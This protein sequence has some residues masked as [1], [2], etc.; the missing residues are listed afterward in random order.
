MG[1]LGRSLFVL[2]LPIT[3]AL[4]AWAWLGRVV[5][6]AGGWFL[7]ILPIF[8]GPWLVLALVLT[9]VLAWT[10]PQRPRVL[11]RRECW[12]LAGLWVGL[13][14]VGLFIVDVGDAPGSEMSIL[15]AIVGDSPTALDVSWWLATASGLLAAAA[16]LTLIVQLILDRAGNRQPTGQP[17]TGPSARPGTPPSARSRTRSVT[18]AR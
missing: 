5:F 6:G 14:G 2:Y 9:V 11:T 10:R 4:V 7:L 17:G 13:F 1:N 12:S 8:V 18:D 15:T 16:W 3:L